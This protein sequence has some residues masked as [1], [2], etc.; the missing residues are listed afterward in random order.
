MTRNRVTLRLLGG[1]AIER[2]GR[3]ISVP[4]SR[5]TRALLAYLAVT[6]RP[7]RRERLCELLFELTDDPRGALRW[8][9][10]K[11]RPLVDDADVTRL[12]ADRDMVRLNREGLGLD[13]DDLRALAEDATLATADA[14]RLEAAVE[15][16]SG[17]FLEGSVIDHAPEFS[18]W[19]AAVRE[20][21]RAQQRRLI[22]ALIERLENAPARRLAAGRRL[23]QLDPFDEGAYAICVRS[24]VELGRAD[25]AAS[26][27]ESAAAA[28][29][30]E[31][32]GL[33]GALDAALRG[34]PVATQP[35]SASPSMQRDKRPRDAR[36]VATVAVLPFRPM[37]EEAENRRWLAD[38]IIDGV[39]DALSRYT[40]LRILAPG[41]T[42]SIDRDDFD[43]VATASAL[44]AD[45]LLTGSL[46]LSRSG[47]EEQLRIRY[48]LIAGTSAAIAWS[49][50]LERSMSDV[51]A[52]QDAAAAEIAN[53]IEPKIASLRLVASTD[54]P[55]VDLVA[56]DYF[57][58]GLASGFRSGAKD[59]GAAADAFEKAL[60][61]APDFA[62]ALAYLPWAQGMAFRLQTA[63]DFTRAIAMARQAIGLAGADARTLAMGAMS[64]V[65]LGQDYAG[66]LPAADRALKLNGNDPVA[67]ISAAWI[68]ATA[69]E[70]DMPMAL[71]ARAAELSPLPETENGNIHAGRAMC[72]LIAGRYADARHWADEAL[73]LS[74]GH[75]SAL[76]SGTAA[77]SGL[78]D[79]DDA[80]R[81]ATL[82]TRLIPTGLASPI[83]RALPFRRKAD[84]EEIFALLRAAGVPG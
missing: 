60:E 25:E 67:L 44:S 2:D 51:F 9:L 21:C 16:L 78:G 37:G 58:R 62:P 15:T 61:I 54:Q 17:D 53:A 35:A 39:A 27:A 71:F 83:V 12:V 1:F 13:L 72:C 46:Q 75:P 20:D 24:L 59:Y 26:L 82:F 22:E 30:R 56:Y 63:Q 8:S 29:R 66:G 6:G 34:A 38:G 31:R 74:P 77:A 76:F 28:F 36:I 50:M 42:A 23:V 41:A 68:R 81:R 33:S 65:F 3:T 69:G 10:A 14:D 18:A 45:Y 4:S 48:R 43:P 79:R 49:G 32:I 7:Q 73:A 55:D 64:L 47:G 70:Y 52:I 5:K 80:Q 40:M 84:R 57:L 11:L 19:V